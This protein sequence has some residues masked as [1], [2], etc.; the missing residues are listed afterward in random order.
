MVL[1]WF[2]VTPWSCSYTFVVT[3][4][5]LLYIQCPMASVEYT[6]CEI[7]KINANCTHHTLYLVHTCKIVIIVYLFHTL[8][9]VFIH[10][11]YV[12]IWERNSYLNYKHAK[13]CIIMVTSDCHCP[14]WAV[15]LSLFP[16]LYACMARAGFKIISFLRLKLSNKWLL[17]EPSMVRLLWHYVALVTSMQM[18]QRH[19]HILHWH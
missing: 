7:Y 4:S 1:K 3:L 9:D 16:G 10:N 5:M 19:L 18:K 15:D 6:V 13:S 12:S 2:S 11:V 8:R 14:I 17:G